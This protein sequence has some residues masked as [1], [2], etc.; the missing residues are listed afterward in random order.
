MMHILRSQMW[1]IGGFAF[2]GYL[3][4]FKYALFMVFVNVLG[5]LD[6]YIIVDLR[7]P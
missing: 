3:Y 2:Y 6:E 4:N 1:S 5:R 7:S